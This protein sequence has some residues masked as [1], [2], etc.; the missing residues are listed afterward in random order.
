MKVEQISADPVIN[1]ALDTI[2]KGKQA[3]LFVGTR[4][5]AEKVAEDIAKKIKTESPELDKL[6]FDALE[7]L[8]KPTQQCERLA[9]TLK[10]GIAFHHSG[11][12]REQKTLIEDAFREGKVRII[13][14]TPTLAAGVDLPA[15][16]AII[17]DL[18]RF[19]DRGM[20]WIPVLEY[21]QMAGRAGRPRFD[22]E[23]QAIVFASTESE[24]EAITEKYLKG[25][26]EEIFS[27]L[28]VEPVLRVYVLSMIAS[29]V[30]TTR[31]RL[32]DFFMKTFWGHQFKDEKKLEHI[33]D[34]MVELLKEWKF[35]KIEDFKSADEDERINATEI[36]RRVSELYLDPLTAHQLIEGLKRV[37]PSSD[38]F[39]FSHLVSFTLEMRP[40]LRV[41][42]REQEIIEQALAS[43]NLLIDEPSLYDEEYED[44]INS[45]KTALFLEEWAEEKD[46]EYLLEKYSIRPGEIRGKLEIADWLL[47]ATYELARM[48]KMQPLLKEIVK[49]RIRLR[50]G[51]KEELLPLLRL[52]GIGRVRARKLHN[53]KIRTIG[54]VKKSDIATL[55]AILGEKVALE[56]K[57]QVESTKKEDKEQYELEEF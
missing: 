43:K 57:K 52:K 12:V 42:T 45:V 30:A 5:S 22:T 6:S 38:L 27:K 3:L 19:G 54:D 50:Y 20:N 17:R 4:P 53:N 16:R 31:A 29:Q 23:G 32:H 1:L 28:A 2:S 56:T 10:K 18:K 15:F 36:G 46:E 40:L 35:V 39:S 41:R 24:A 9:R 14:C 7:A 26:P 33:I 51:V 47:Y 49:T 8:Q 25:E 55:K 34:R 37:I 13:C 48:L 21:L 44:F 11:L